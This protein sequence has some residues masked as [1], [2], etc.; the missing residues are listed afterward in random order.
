[1]TKQKMKVYFIDF[2]FHPIFFFGLQLNVICNLFNMTIKIL[3]TNVACNLKL[4]VRTNCKM[5]IFY[6][7]KLQFQKPKYEKNENVNLNHIN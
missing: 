5:V 3:I 6:Y 1:M 7:Y 4:Y 2:F